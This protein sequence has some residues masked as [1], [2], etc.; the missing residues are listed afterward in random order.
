MTVKYC[1]TDD[2]ANLSGSE[3]SVAV[4]TAI[5]EQAE[6]EIDARLAEHGLSGSGDIIKSASLE[7]SLAGLFTRMRLDGSKPGT[8]TIGPSTKTDA[9]DTAIASHKQ[10]A[11]ELVDLFIKVTTEASEPE[12]SY[13]A[14]TNE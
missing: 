7:L 4:L 5:I 14:I 6:R 12:E 10:R 2:L 8:L 9:I 11:W 13:I 1:T 3:L